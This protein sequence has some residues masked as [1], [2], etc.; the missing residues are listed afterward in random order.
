MEQLK[1]PTAEGNQQAGFDITIFETKPNTNSKIRK[2]S[3][4]YS[5]LEALANGQTLNRFEA[6]RCLHDHCLNSTISE[7]QNR[8]GVFIHRKSEKV[9][10]LGGTKRVK[11]NRY[12]LF[13][14]QVEKAQKLLGVA[15]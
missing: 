4:I 6:E 8:L 12:R 5:V 13:P 15:A 14:D 10:C 2:G 3:K 1:K 7:I 11:V 9:P